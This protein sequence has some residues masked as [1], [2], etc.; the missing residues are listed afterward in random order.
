MKSQ[1]AQ[2]HAARYPSCRQAQ[3]IE[4]WGLDI[5]VLPISTRE[6][7]ALAS[8]PKGALYRAL[9]KHFDLPF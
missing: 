3:V 9:L 1:F 7:V 8:A 2:N 4:V 5:V 6:R